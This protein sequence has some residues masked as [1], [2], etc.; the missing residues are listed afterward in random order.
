MNH[1][2]MIFLM[3]GVMFLPMIGIAVTLLGGFLYIIQTRIKRKLYSKVII[4]G[5]LCIIFLAVIC[6][7]LAWIVGGPGVFNV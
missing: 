4:L 7:V 2:L 5:G 6:A 3:G 1:D